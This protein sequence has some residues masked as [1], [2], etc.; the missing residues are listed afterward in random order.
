MGLLFGPLWD[1]AKQ[2]EATSRPKSLKASA[3]MKEMNSIWQRT[4]NLDLQDGRFT[5]KKNSKIMFDGTALLDVVSRYRANPKA[6]ARFRGQIRHSVRVH[7]DSLPTEYKPQDK[8][9]PLYKYWT[10]VRIAIRPPPV[11]RAQLMREAKAKASLINNADDIGSD[12]N[13]VQYVYHPPTHPHT[14]I[15]DNLCTGQ[16]ILRRW[17]SSLPLPWTL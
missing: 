11:P 16:N 17:S 13:A 4:C 5:L 10:A 15:I 3:M 6:R 7:Y 8:A 2:C 9:L 12:N 14:H 1:K